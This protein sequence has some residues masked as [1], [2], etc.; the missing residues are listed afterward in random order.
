MAGTDSGGPRTDS[1]MPGTD[2]G[3]PGNGSGG[4]VGTPNVVIDEMRATGEDWVELYDAGT[5]V[6]DH[7]G[8]RV[9]DRA[10]DDT[11]KVS[12]TVAFRTGMT[13]A[14]GELF[15]V[16]A[17]LRAPREG[18]QSDCALRGASG[19]LTC[20]EVGFGPSDCRSDTVHLLHCPRIRIRRS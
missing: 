4:P 13:L 9:C 2:A 19:L 12:D 14:P 11:P 18:L 10:N 3:G 7:S 17:D 15:A 1:G 16:V 20:R 5:A 6:A 8:L